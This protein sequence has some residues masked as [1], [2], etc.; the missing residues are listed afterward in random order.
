MADKEKETSNSQE[1][2][3]KIF[4]TDDMA[5]FC[6]AKGFIYTN[7]EIYGGMKGFFDY[8]PLGSEMKKNLKDAWWKFHVQDREDIV[9]IDGTI[10]THPKVWEASGH[11]ANFEDLM[12]E[13]TKCGEK[14]RADVFIEEKLNVAAD[15]WKADQVNKTI[16]ENKLVC[17]SCKG[18]FKEVEQFNLMFTTNVGPKQDKE[19]LAYLRPE[20]AQLMFTNFKQVVET[21]RL[22]LPF[23]IAQMGRAFRNEISP[24]NFLFRCREFEQMEIEYFIHPKDTDNCPYIADVLDHELMIYSA[25]DQEDGKDT[26][27]TIMKIRD[28]LDKKIIKTQWHGYW[29]ATE[30]RWF[31]SLGA[32]A[33]NFRIRQHVST[34]KSHYALDTWDLEY[35]FP[36]GWKELQG[37]ANRTDF[38]LQQHIKHSKKDLSLFDE[39]AKERIVPH[40]VAEPSQGVDR[41]FLVFMFDA[42]DDDKERGNIVLHLSSKLAPYKVGVFSLVN[43]NLESARAVFKE[44]QSDFVCMFDKS[45]SIG[46]RYAR[47]DEIGIPYCVTV[48]FDYDEKNTVTIRDRESTKQIIVD[49]DKLK[50]TLSRLLSGNIEF[51]KAGTLKE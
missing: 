18:A 6:R 17:D 3:Q 38:D 50:D 4:G 24:R 27:G 29:L 16:Q 15:G 33:G 2:Q 34:E 31:I 11:V 41:A 21:S 9:G 7:S 26:E 43:K 46:R 35:R 37:M 10:I 36:W 48:D 28:A 5:T 25:C 47:A 30:H 45:G 39:E 19:S 8:G 51:E 40:V 1:N 13:C 42:Y 14:V 32:K 12:L 44:L 49:K 20:T 22:K 23:G